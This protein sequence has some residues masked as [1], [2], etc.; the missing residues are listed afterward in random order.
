M[1]EYSFEPLRDNSLHSLRR[2]ATYVGAPVLRCKKSCCQGAMVFLCPREKFTHISRHTLYLN[3]WLDLFRKISQNNSVRHT[4]IQSTFESCDPT[5]RFQF[6]HP[7]SAILQWRTWWSNRKTYPCLRSYLS[8]FR[9]EGKLVLWLAPAVRKPWVKIVVL[10]LARGAIVLAADLRHRFSI[11]ITDLSAMCNRVR[12]RS[13][14]TRLYVLRCA[15]RQHLASSMLR[16]SQM[17]QWRHKQTKR[18]LV[19]WVQVDPATARNRLVSSAAVQFARA[20]NRRLTKSAVTRSATNVEW[21]RSVLIGATR[22]GVKCENTILL[23]TEGPCGSIRECSADTVTYDTGAQVENVTPIR[24]CGILP[25]LLPGCEPSVQECTV[26][27]TGTYAATVYSTFFSS[28]NPTRSGPRSRSL[29]LT[30]QR[31]FSSP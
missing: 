12:L 23:E 9:K 17:K 31:I 11:L 20:A 13:R 1:T 28:A 29:P 2:R 8:P 18:G 21:V 6:F 16:K 10:L 30:C 5:C 14:C 7:L 19:T 24:I 22:C 26:P 4:T 25:V 27:Y 15:F 3:R